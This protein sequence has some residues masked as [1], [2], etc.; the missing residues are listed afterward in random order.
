MLD[1]ERSGL[2]LHTE[3]YEACVEFYRDRIGLPVELEKNEP[4][5]ILTLLTLGSSYLMIE[6]GGV[7]RAA[8][9]AAHENP[10][11]IRF[12]VPDVD[13]AAER[14]RRLGVDVAVS[15]FSW[16]TIGD[17]CDPD[18]NRCQFRE[19]LSFGR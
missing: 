10:V 5:Q 8:A 6:P 7:A 17:F 12:N 3:K 16:G 1:L 4:G 14:L 2:I 19:A 11:T 15:K 13:T 18:G 9:K